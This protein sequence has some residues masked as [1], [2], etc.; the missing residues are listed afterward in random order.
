MISGSLARRYARAL[1]DLGVQN[2]TF[3]Q[4]GKELDELAA[5]YSGSRDLT[6]ALTN[7]VF[8]HTRRRDVLMA[9]LEEAKASP[10]VRNFVLLLFDR[11]RMPYLP[12]IARELRAMVDERGGRARATVTS[13]RA[14]TADQVKKV[15]ASLEKLSGKQILLDKKTDAGLI[16]GIVAKVGDTVYDGSIRTQLEQMRERFLAE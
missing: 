12:G 16:G 15:K 9:I 2:D 5:M 8:S 7:P 3:E 1:L 4:I 6:E 13:A 11:E 10:V 14:L